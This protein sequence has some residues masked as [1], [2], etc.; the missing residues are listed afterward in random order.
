MLALG[1]VSNLLCFIEFLDVFSKFYILFTDLCSN[2]CKVFSIIESGIVSTD[3]QS[4]WF[5][6]YVVHYNLSFFS[7]D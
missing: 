1:N 2:H 7:N 3:F 6:F 5:V 4:K